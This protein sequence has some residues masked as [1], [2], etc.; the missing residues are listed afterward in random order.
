MPR[1]LRII[2]RFNIGGPT[3][4]AAI[5]TKYLNSSYET[6]LV[7]GAHQESESS[8]NYILESLGI[9]GEVIPS[10]KREF[11]FTDDR[12]AYRDIRKIIKEYKP[13]IIHTHASK[14]GAIGRAAGIN[15]RKAKMIHTFHGHVFHSYFGKVKT[16]FYKTIERGLARKTDK[17]IAISNIQKQELVNQF[18]ICS[19]DKVEVIPLG[20]DLERFYTDTPSKREVF[21][22]KYQ[23]SDDEIA[24]GIVGRLTQ[25]KNHHLFLK[26]FQ[27]AKRKSKRKIRAFIIGDGED[28]SKLISYCKQLGL[29]YTT[30]AFMEDTQVDKV[31]VHFI[32][33]VKDMD[34]PYAGVDIVALT[35]NNEGTPVSLIEAQAASKPIVST[36]V[37]GVADIV[38]RDK[39][40]LLAKPKNAGEFSRQMLRLIEDEK[41]RRE[42]SLRSKDFAI[43]KFHYERLVNDIYNLYESVLS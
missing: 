29:T 4:N 19:A 10:M 15:Y 2:N 40:A 7:G 25:I 24:I 26:A 42:L 8:S 21:R 11:K 41:L 30:V 36:E 12:Q 9:E 17:I 28:K 1:I 6:R 37:G 35:S 32:S 22:T 16:N 31:D 38:I 5:L 23:L 3:Y 13:D 18:K 14:A 33:W 43:Q 39:T 20:F 27:I 34:V